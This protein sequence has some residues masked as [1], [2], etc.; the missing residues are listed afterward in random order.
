MAVNPA[1]LAEPQV[2]TEAVPDPQLPAEEVAYY[3]AKATEPRISHD[4][5]KNNIRKYFDD[6]EVGEDKKKKGWDWYRQEHEH[7][8]KAAAAPGVNTSPERFAGIVAATSPNNT[9][10]ANIA[11][12]QRVAR[13]STDHPDED[14]DEFVP[15]LEHPGYMKAGVIKGIKIHRGE[16]LATV[17]GDKKIY[18]FHHNL[19]D[20]EGTEDMVTMDR[21]MHRA[22]VGGRETTSK[23]TSYFAKPGYD[24]GADIVRE[25]ASEVGYT[26]QQLQAIIWTEIKRTWPRG[27]R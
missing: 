1:D 5:A 22:L 10:S 9:W 15:K 26:P 21:W 2:A 24:W 6:A 11:T 25:V 13:L 4:A 17:L 19:V 16:D 8:A 20:P 12:A 23:E 18:N 7:I 14:P 27:I 3:D